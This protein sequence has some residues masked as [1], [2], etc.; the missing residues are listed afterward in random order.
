M[1]QRLNIVVFNYAAVARLD[2][3]EYVVKEATMAKL[4]S[5]KVADEAIY[6]CLQMLGGGI[7]KSI[8]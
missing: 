3:G 7:W 2:K 6:S 5:T 1:Q 8:L 4:K